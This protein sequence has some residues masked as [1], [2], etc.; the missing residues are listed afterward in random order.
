MV[1]S[2]RAAM[3][4]FIK[5]HVDAWEVVHTVLFEGVHKDSSGHVGVMMVLLGSSR[6]AVGKLL[7][8]G[9]MVMRGVF[10]VGKSQLG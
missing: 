4:G 8:F 10:A 6:I 7:G 2:N 1:R 5:R 3:G 9:A